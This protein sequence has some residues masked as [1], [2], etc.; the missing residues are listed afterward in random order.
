VDPPGVPPAKNLT[1]S[2]RD[3]W[4]DNIAPCWFANWRLSIFLHELINGLTRGAK[5]EIVPHNR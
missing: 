5:A 2:L 4:N 3:T 1:I